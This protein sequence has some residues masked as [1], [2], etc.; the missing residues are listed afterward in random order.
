[1]R[2][3][4]LYHFYIGIFAGLA[5][6]T[7][8]AIFSTMFFQRKELYE[9]A[10]EEKISLAAVVNDAL[11]S[12]VAQQRLYQSFVVERVFISEMAKFSEVIL[13]RMVDPEGRIIHSNLEQELNQPVE[14]LERAKSEI[15]RTIVTKQHIVKEIF[16]R[17]QKLKLII[18][19]AFEDRTIWIGFSTQNIDQ[20]IR[21]TTQ[22]SLVI[23][24]GMLGLIAFFAFLMLRYLL[25][26]L[27]QLTMA[28]IEIGKGNLDTK[29]D[30][31]SRTEIGELATTFNE[32]IG[33]LKKAREALE[34]EKMSLEIKVGARTKE[35]KELNENLEEEVRRR[36]KEVYEKIEQLE[37]FQKI[38]VGRELKMV[39]FK[40]EI[41]RLKEE[42]VK[43][44]KG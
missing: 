24:F 39:E 15:A 3:Y 18:F 41:T 11:G 13:L 2:K 40:K 9:R 27:R 4:S 44:S 37:R 36:T 28:C 26:P 16:F 25:N 14:D 8:L 23:G 42:L 30:V 5:V 20:V 32:M 29:I 31:K 17:E 22:R 38:A 43:K 21:S 1:M 10:I 34:E 12:L 19:P 7:V 35:L 6:V 33:D